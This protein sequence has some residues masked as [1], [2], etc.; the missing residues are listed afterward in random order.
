MAGKRNK[1]VSVLVGVSGGVDSAAALLFLEKQGFSV[2]GIYFKMSNNNLASDENYQRAKRTAVIIGVPLFRKNIFKEF[3]KK[4]IQSFIKSYK[5]NLTPNPCVICNSEIK[6]KFLI[7]EAEK[8][9]FDFI[10]TGHYA[11]IERDKKGIFNLLKGKDKFKDQSYFL[12]RLKQGELKKSIFPLGKITKKETK[13]II[14]RSILRGVDFK[15][16]SQ[17]IC[18]LN[19][20]NNLTNFLLS[21]ARKVGKGKIVNEKGEILGKHKGLEFYTQGQRYGLNLAGGPYFVIGK[22][23]GK[24]ELTVSKRKNHPRLLSK[25]IK[26]K[27]TSWI[28]NQ[29]VPNKNYY[30]KSRYT[31]K[32]AKGYF[33]KCKD[34]WIAILNKKQWAVAGGQSLVVYNGQKVVGGGIIETS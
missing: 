29:P 28:S 5:K 11:R 9:G 32:L 34:G 7:S 4:I 25:K 3:D 17:D 1:K 19:N 16:E 14:N 27:K 30:F 22:N 21:K 12:Y 10:A 33:K 6:F 26:I 2:A 20:K 24:K 13:K 23:I 31:S 18:F 15:K 8:R